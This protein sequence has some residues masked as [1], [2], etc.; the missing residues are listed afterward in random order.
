MGGKVKAGEAVC[1]DPRTVL[2]LLVFV[3]AVVFSHSSLQVELILI[4]VLLGLFLCCGLFR[5]G[6]KF[7][8][9]FGFL[10]A[11]QYYI[12]PAAPKIFSDFFFILTVYA[13]KVFP[14]AMIGRF[15][16]ETTP[17][18]YV[19]LAMRSWYFPQRLIIP[20]SVTIRYFPA[21]REEIGHIRNA[22]KLRR[23]TGTARIE[24]YIVPLIFSALNT[25]EELG[26]A[27][28][29][30]GIENPAPKTSVIELRFRLRDYVCISVGLIFALAAF[31]LG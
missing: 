22:M 4:G 26:A 3:T 27:A 14:C 20:L 17:M 29:T 24:A 30:R 11:L 6:V 10:L 23:V 2:L 5:S 16:V 15:I 12:L 9:G 8:L 21:I 7:M 13:R 25:A 1:L 19:I 31:F 28:V 18:R